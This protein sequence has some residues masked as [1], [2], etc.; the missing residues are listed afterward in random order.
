M[1]KFDQKGYCPSEELHPWKLLRIMKLTIL[2]LWI[3]MMGVH[4]TG[5]SQKSRMDVKIRN[6]NLATLFRQIQEQTSYRIFYRDDIFSGKEEININ[7]NLKNETVPAILN[8]ALKG[9]DL[10]YKVIG[11]QIAVYKK[12]END[13]AGPVQNHSMPALPEV[14]IREINGTIADVKGNPLPGATVIVKGTDKGTSADASGKFTVEAEQGDVLVISFIGYLKK[15]QTVGAQTTLNIQLEEDLNGL[16]EIVIVG[17]GSQRKATI[18]GSIATI[19][20]EDLKQS[21]TASIT[22]ALAGRLPGLFANQFSGGEPGVDRSDIF[23]RGTATYGNKAPI[24]IIDGL[25]RSMDYLAPSEIETFTILKDAS[26]TAPYGVRGAN[27]VILITTRRGKVQDKATVNFKASVGV[28]QPVKFP[29][30]LGSADYAMLYNEARRNDNPEADPSTLNLFSEQ[31]I[32]DFRR[33]KGDNSDGLGYNWNY[34][35][36][37]FKP[38]VQHD[39]SL[40]ISGGSLR[41]T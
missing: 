4:A 10:T 26:A 33:A 29:T 16:E 38:G 25:E 34:F 22:N 37:A 35:D 31:A 28:N 1:K 24:V 27:G 36:Y 3:A 15:E 8:A 12:E 40:S 6:G 7:L 14:V 21:P 13:G 11:K 9:T 19:T 41:D 20:T 17:Y 2:L 5:Y 30:Y 32:A 39:Y 18:T 23:I